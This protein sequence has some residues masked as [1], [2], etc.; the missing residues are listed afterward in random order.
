MSDISDTGSATPAKAPV[1]TISIRE[2]TGEDVTAAF[3]EGWRDLKAA[4][5]LSL[6]FG[7]VYALLGAAIAGLLWRNAA[8]YMIFPILG[9]FLLVA[10]ITA[11]GL[12]EI[13]RRLEV[14]EPLKAAAVITAFTRHGGLQLGVFG[15]IL[16]FIALFWAKAAAFIYALHFGLDPMPIE[17]IVRAVVTTG[18]GLQFFFIGT[19]VGAV[20]ATLVFAISVIGVP[21]LLDRDVDPVTAMVTSLRAVLK[22]PVAFL[23]FAAMVVWLTGIGIGFAFLGLIV[24]LPLV[25]HATWR[26]YRKVVV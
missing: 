20:L 17:E 24:M 8:E 19:A 9:M 18:L 26:L 3:A 4:P 14:G 1:D 10:P 15:V 16:F 5:L 23:G 21:M 13:S 12:Y 11:V 25:G 2:I 22:S 7:L 6:L